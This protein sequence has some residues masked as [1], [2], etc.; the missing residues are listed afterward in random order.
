[1]NVKVNT[2]C[3]GCIITLVCSIADV[4]NDIADNVT[5][6]VKKAV[7]LMKQTGS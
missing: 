7:Q 5:G 2:A 3:Y 1:M 6:V 4:H